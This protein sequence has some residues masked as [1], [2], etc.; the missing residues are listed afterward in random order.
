VRVVIDDAVS[1]D[2]GPVTA[3]SFY[4]NSGNVDELFG[5]V[6]LNEIVAVIQGFEVNFDDISA[7][8]VDPHRESVW[9]TIK[10]SLGRVSEFGGNSYQRV[11]HPSQQLHPP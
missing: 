4:L 10:E 1:H 3:P 9:V 5:G 2:I 11:T 6:T 7:G 8:V